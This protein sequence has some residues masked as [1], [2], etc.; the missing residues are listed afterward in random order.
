MKNIEDFK[1]YCLKN[2]IINPKVYENENCFFAD[3]SHLDGQK[4]NSKILAMFHHVKD[5]ITVDNKSGYTLKFFKD[6][7]DGNG[8]F[9][10]KINGTILPHLH[11][12]F[13]E[14]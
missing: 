14:N 13:Y 4:M 6:S 9:G 11:K 8:S 2:G 3:A 1:Q 5:Y 12:Y 10:W 7:R